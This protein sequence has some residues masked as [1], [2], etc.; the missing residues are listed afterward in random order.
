[1][2]VHVTV[3]IPTFNRPRQLEACLG[4]L[5]ASTYP[6]HR[7][8]VVVVDD[9]GSADLDSVI[10]ARRAA[11]PELGL[12]LERT[13]RGGPAAA[14]NAGAA[15][16]RGALLAFTD[17][18]CLPEADW[19]DA[20]VR[21]AAG[22]PNHLIGGQTSN[23]LT[24]NPFSAASQFLVSY[25]YEYSERQRANPGWVGFFTS[26][27]MAVPADGFHRVGGFDTSFP[28]AAGE[29]REFCDRWLASGLP[30]ALAPDARVRHAHHLGPASFW[31]QHWN[32]GRGAFHFNRARARR[33][34]GPLRP[35]PFAFYADL[36]RYPFRHGSGPRAALEAAL[37]AASQGANALGYF[38]ERFRARA[39]PD[40][41]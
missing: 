3:V 1:L 40:S 25:L 11:S 26:N 31:R 28:L 9:G 30:T 29:D 16:A 10:G 19:L 27:N 14:R 32:Y 21:C 2:S 13:G 36:V 37:L 18:D 8:E 15:L 12:R 5:A 22:R 7:F 34:A 35:Q 17:D 38:C 33:G 41:A 39:A 4:A 6:A 20:L 24:R 23:Q